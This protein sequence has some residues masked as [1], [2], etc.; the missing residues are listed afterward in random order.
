MRRLPS[1]DF[2]GF[3]YLAVYH[4]PA[5][6]P[7]R[8][9][10]TIESRMLSH[11]VRNLNSLESRIHRKSTNTHRPSGPTEIESNILFNFAS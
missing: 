7:F 6:V 1:K 2:L 3:D 5:L 9:A 11:F 8:Q 4:T 10:A